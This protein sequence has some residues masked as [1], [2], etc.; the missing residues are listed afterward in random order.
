M[1]KEQEEK[2]HVTQDIIYKLSRLLRIQNK[3]TQIV[4]GKLNFKYVKYVPLKRFT[5]YRRVIYS[6]GDINDINEPLDILIILI[7]TRLRSVTT[8][9]QLFQAKDGYK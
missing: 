1:K 8:L 6:N 4:N 7:V 3:C 2:R 5:F 9:A